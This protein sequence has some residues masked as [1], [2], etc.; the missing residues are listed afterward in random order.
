MPL[1]L[2]QKMAKLKD[3]PDVAEEFKYWLING[4]YKKDNAIRIEEYSAKDIAAMSP[5]MDGE[6]A[7]MLLI[8]LRENPEKAKSRISDGFFKM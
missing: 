1:L 2:K 8:E 6:G 7:F 3:N 4:C 5:Y